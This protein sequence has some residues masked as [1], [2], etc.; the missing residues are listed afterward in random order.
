[1]KIVYAS[2]TGFTKEYAQMLS[3]ELSLEAYDVKDALSLLKEGE[4]I[5]YLAYIRAGGLRYFNKVNRKFKI[6]SIGA[7]G[8]SLDSTQIKG[9]RKR[10]RINPSVGLFYMQGGYAPDRIKGCDK[11]AMSI[12]KKIIIKQ[13]SKKQELT[14][15]ERDALDLALNGGSRVNKEALTDI[16]SFIKNQEKA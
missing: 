5:I 12:V 13:L 9:I 15:I 2:G 4:T 6:V 7:V 1:M 10:H 14:D 8:M 11:F 3:K 16:I